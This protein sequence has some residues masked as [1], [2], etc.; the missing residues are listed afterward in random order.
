MSKKHFNAI[1][2]SI[3]AERKDRDDGTPNA[4]ASLETIDALARTLAHQFA[5]FNAAFD[6]NR[7]L[8]ACGVTA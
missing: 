1:A 3:A 8:A 5:G 6:R 4:A 2:A 7:F